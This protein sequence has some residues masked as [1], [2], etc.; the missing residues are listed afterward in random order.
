VIGGI[1]GA[2][3]VGA[4]GAAAVAC[5]LLCSTE[6]PDLP[7]MMNQEAPSGTPPAAADSGPPASAPVGNSTS[8][9]EVTPGTNEPTT[10]GNT[11]FSGHAVDRMQGRG[12]PP[13]VV[14]DT[15][16]N[17]Q[18]APG[19]QPGTTTHY[20]PTNNVT[21]VTNTTTGNVITIRKGAP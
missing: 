15:I 21:V 13:S 6:I 3:A 11:P 7:V 12:I 5:V 2:A 17:G 20:D 14:T 19:N 16:L 10:I 8:P 18:T 9:I 1:S 4:A